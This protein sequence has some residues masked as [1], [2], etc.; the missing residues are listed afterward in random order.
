MKDSGIS[1]QST[2]LLGEW[3]SDSSFST[4]PF[5]LLDVTL[6]RASYYCFPHLCCL[7]LLSQFLL[8]YLHSCGMPSVKVQSSATTKHCTNYNDS[9]LQAVCLQTALH[10]L[11]ESG[12][13]WKV[14]KLTV[15]VLC[16]SSSIQITFSK[17]EP[18]SPDSRCY[19]IHS[20]SKEKKESENQRSQ[21]LHSPREKLSLHTLGDVAAG[22][23]CWSLLDYLSHTR[24]HTVW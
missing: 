15:V 9:A 23:W 11:E 24:L 22:C 5:W 20:L 13:P 7:T 3:Q 6:L 12:N 14:Y 1:N 16:S 18:S 8:L 10:F 4:L 19:L 17:T 2:C 21:P